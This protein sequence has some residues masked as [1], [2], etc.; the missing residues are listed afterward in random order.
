MPVGVLKLHMHSD[1]APVPFLGSPAPQGAITPLKNAG[2]RGH[3]EIQKMVSWVF[4]TIRC[5][6]MKW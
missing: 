6:E 4:A 3:A 1:S 5:S 2:E